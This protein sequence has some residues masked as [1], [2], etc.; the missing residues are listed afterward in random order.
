MD[1]SQGLRTE[2]DWLRN[3]GLNIVGTA[4]HNS[5]RV[6]NA[7]NFA[8]F[9]GRPLRS[10]QAPEDC[11]EIAVKDGNH[12]FLQELDELELAL[13]YEANEIFAQT[14][15]PMTY[16]A[17]RGR[18]LWRFCNRSAEGKFHPTTPPRKS[19]MITTDEVLNR[20]E[21]IPT[22]SFLNL[23]LHP[24][25]FGSRASA[26]AFPFYRSNS[27]TYAIGVWPRGYQPNSFQSHAPSKTLLA[28]RQ[29]AHW[30]NH[31]GMLDRIDIPDRLHRLLCLGGENLDGLTIPLNSQLPA[32]LEEEID[33]LNTTKFAFPEASFAALKHWHAKYIVDNGQ[34]N[35]VLLR[36]ENKK[37]RQK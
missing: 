31:N 11:P 26:K 37:Q 20:I 18:N 9:K 16:I 15:A 35:A 24:V 6:Y 33:S 19:E 22:G 27:R 13:S 34:P 21:K 5:F 10:G 30:S 28:D 1:G 14:C 29:T 4:A 8:V 12:C 7:E 3:Q 23:V 25:Y 17:H 36:H 2:L 32:V